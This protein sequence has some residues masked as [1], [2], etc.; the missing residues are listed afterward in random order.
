MSVL[1]TILF[2]AVYIGLCWLIAHN[3]RTT[4]FGF[5]GN[6]AVSLVLS[7]LVGLLVLL[8]QERN[9]QKKS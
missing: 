5:W 6:F 9:Y 4:K 1:Y 3:G 2:A 7:P 8:A